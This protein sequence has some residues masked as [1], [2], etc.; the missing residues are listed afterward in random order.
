MKK[1]LLL[2]LLMFSL[3]NINAQNSTNKREVFQQTLTEANTLLEQGQFAEALAK[4]DEALAQ[5]EGLYDFRY[6]ALVHFVRGK[7]FYGMGGK[8]CNLR[9]RRTW[10]ICK[11]K[12]WRC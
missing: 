1:C 7:V 3:T 8:A 6:Q 10:S 4:S 9:C 11:S 5:A 12:T 2:V